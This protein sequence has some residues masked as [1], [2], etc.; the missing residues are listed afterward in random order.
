MRNTVLFVSSIGMVWANFPFIFI[1]QEGTFIKSYYILGLLTS[2]LNHGCNSRALQVAD[3]AVMTLGFFVDLY[4]MYDVEELL[5]V[6]L[7]IICYFMSKITKQ[8]EFH[9]LS[10]TLI[11]IAHNKILTHNYYVY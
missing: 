2:L 4:Y 9:V 6:F 7:S 10:H 8:I 3:R 11:T 1:S 5:F